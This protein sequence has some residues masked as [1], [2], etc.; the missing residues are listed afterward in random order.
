MPRVTGLWFKNC[1]QLWGLMWGWRSH[2]M[3]LAWKPAWE[4]EGAT[5]GSSLEG[6]VQEGHLLGLRAPGGVGWPVLR[7]GLLLD[8][9]KP[10]LNTEPR[11]AS[12]MQREQGPSS[13]VRTQLPAP[14]MCS[15]PRA[16][17]GLGPDPSGV[18]VQTLSCRNKVRVWSPQAQLSTHQAEHSRR[19]PR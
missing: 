14:M 4:A 18:Q 17:Q 2:I 7:G 10:R 1:Q 16:V 6:K 3:A 13:L 11:N 15:Q 9:Q 12:Q 8:V 5:G 19:N